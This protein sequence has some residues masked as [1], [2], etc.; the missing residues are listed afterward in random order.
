[1]SAEK[2]LSY[3]TLK[4]AAEYCH[5]SIRHLQEEVRRQRLRAYK[6]G[7]CVLFEVDELNKWIKKKAIS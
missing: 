5:A 2:K 7:K 6:P 4:E 3:M 1:M